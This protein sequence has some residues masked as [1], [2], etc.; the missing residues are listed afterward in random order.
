[1]SNSYPVDKVN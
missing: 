1:V